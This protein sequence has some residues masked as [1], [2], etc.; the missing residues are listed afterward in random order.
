MSPVAICQ[1]RAQPDYR[2]DA[3]DQGLRKAGYSV[4]QSGRA[5]GPQDLLCVWNLYGAGEMMA[6]AWERAGG[7][8]LVCENGYLG[9]DS[10]GRQRY[11]ISAHA[12]N[13]AGWL[14]EPQ[15][16]RFAALGIELQ[17]WR[18]S[19]DDAAILICG[20][21]GIGSRSM[22]SPAAWHDHAARRIKAVTKRRVRI[23]PHPGN[24]PAPITL[25]VD[26]QG[27]HAVAVWSSSSGVKALAA[28]YPVFYDAPHWIAAEGAMKLHG[29]DFE[30]PLM[31]DAARLRALRTMASAQWSVEEIES[32]EPFVRFREAA[33]TREAVP[34]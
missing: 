34:C 32:G 26:M 22:A 18:A 10:E 2:R 7:T 8:V 5:T 23:R 31:D 11:A 3:F 33:I 27:A 1:I 9:K 29:A 14:P 4:V 6:G 28:G 13:G 15:E 30:R 20:Q 24:Q 19:S 25:D 12:H 21:R 16:D 17:P